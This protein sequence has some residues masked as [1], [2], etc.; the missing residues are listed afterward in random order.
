M[1]AP[2]TYSITAGSH[3][4]KPQQQTHIVRV[5]HG[6]TASLDFHI[7]ILRL[8]KPEYSQEDE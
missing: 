5:G 4:D 8:Q 1:V 7:W 6:E 2:G 3:G